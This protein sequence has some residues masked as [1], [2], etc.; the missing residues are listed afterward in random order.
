[1]GVILRK[2]FFC[3]NS[4]YRGKIMRKIDCAHSRSVEMLPWPWFRENIEFF[5]L[6]YTST[7]FGKTFLHKLP[8]VV[9]W[10]SSGLLGTKVARSN[11]VWRQIFLHKVKLS[12][13]TLCKNLSLCKKILIQ[14]GFEPANFVTNKKLLCHCTTDAS[15]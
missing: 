13:F 3:Q 7:W 12:F 11:P 1:M 6:F 5:D 2:K 8:S 14:A 10:Q 15:L 9:Q 4:L